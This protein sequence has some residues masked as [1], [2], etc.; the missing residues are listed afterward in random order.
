MNQIFK[1][2]E[3]SKKSTKPIHEPNFLNWA[4]KGKIYKTPVF[5]LF[6]GQKKRSMIPK[7]DILLFLFNRLEKPIDFFLVTTAAIGA[8]NETTFKLFN[9]H[10]DCLLI[11]STTVFALPVNHF[12]A[13]RQYFVRR[14][15]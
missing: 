10:S 1:M 14:K 8:R 13:C 3:K 6:H 9:T 7:L 15:S 11:F 5:D 2:R 4:K 12:S